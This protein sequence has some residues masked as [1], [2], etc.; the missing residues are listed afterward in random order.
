MKRLLFLAVG[1]VGL[2]GCS[3]VQKPAELKSLPQLEPL[4]PS[5]AAMDAT[6]QYELIAGELRVIGKA[7]QAYALKHNGQL[8]PRLTALVRESYLPAG[9]LISSA[10]PSGGKEG[11]VPNSYEQWGQAAE[12]DEPGSS[13][14]YEFSEAPCQWDWKS[15][16]G[17][18]PTLAD[19]DLNR[20]GVASWAEVKTW[21]MHH[22]DSVQKP[23]NKAYA[24]SQFPVVRCYW[25][26][27]PAAY[28]NVS[29]R[30]VVNLAADLRTVFLSQPQWEK[31]L[32]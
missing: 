19:A 2:S 20:D 26:K 17:D 10:D 23:S 15:Y 31:D 4:L 16:V 12:T 24:P 9:A 13:Y 11:G 7:L 1:I 8:P 28:A 27:Y 25:Y 21:Q 18:H 29:E 30:S 3:S 5:Y 22:G 6:A 32:Q 14:L